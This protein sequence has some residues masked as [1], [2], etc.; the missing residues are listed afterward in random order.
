MTIHRLKHAFT[1]GELD[2]YMNSRIDFDRRQNGCKRLFNAFCLTQGPAVRRPGFQFIYDLNKLYVNT[3]DP[4]IR[5]IPFVFNEDQAYAMI[6]FRTTQ[7]KVRLVFGTGDGLVV[8][9]GEERKY[10][11]E[12][13][14]DYSGPGTYTMSF[15]PGDTVTK[16]TAFHYHAGTETEITT[17]CS[18]SY[19]NGVAT[20]VASGTPADED[21]DY[22]IFKLGATSPAIPKGQVVYLNMPKG[23]DIEHFDWAQSAD[24]MYIAQSPLAPHLLT[25]YD[26]DHWTISK[27]TVANQLPEWGPT[28][29]DADGDVVEQG[30]PEKVTF[31]Q[32]RLVFAANT[33]RR[34]TVWC[35][36]AG[37]FHDFG[38]DATNLKDDDAVTFTLD[39][40][41][42]NKIQWLLS[43]KALNIGTVANEWTVT[44]SDRFALTPT[45]ILAQRQTN[46]GSMP[47]K[48]LMIGITTIFVERYG[49]VINEFVYD[50]TFDS[51]KSTDMAILSRHI[52]RHYP[53]IDWTYQQTP[54]GIIW[55]VRGDGQLAGVTYQRQHK[56]VGWHRHDTDG[57]F[58]A[59]TCIPGNNYEDE[60]W[61]TV[62]REINGDIHFYVEKLG[63]RFKA[64]HPKHGKFLDS[65]LYYR[66]EAVNDL[67]GLEHL[68]GKE[69]HILADG[70]VHPNRTVLGGHIDLNNYYEYVTVGLPYETEIRPFLADIGAQDGVLHGRTQRITSLNIDFHNS[71]GFYVGRYSH[72][73][74]SFEE[75]RPFRIPGDLTGQAVPLYTGIYHLDFIEGF[76]RKSDYYIKQKQPLP[77]V[78]RGVEDTVEVYE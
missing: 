21:N 51:Y 16:F 17:K 11:I 20:I 28:A 66:G 57:K 1:A 76:D 62:E 38:Y 48:P 63:T 26:H 13:K 5:M 39:A 36:K 75:E 12:S 30:W 44:G 71:L 19:A 69:V 27:L 18:A 68:E 47:N 41:T 55:C 25:R 7:N 9:S 50:F 42:Q 54:D 24:E 67:D 23:W 31:H 29:P 8:G 22:V 72:E 73:D 46:N 3:K 58:K 43:A 49:R 33:L 74:R 56:V 14:Q 35:S 40:G 4:Q 59:I 77:L 37:S 45:N 10:E 61:T 15:T 52:T 32:Q 60:V 65:Y 34:Q 2:P 78:V 64:R 53:L 70:T 6:F